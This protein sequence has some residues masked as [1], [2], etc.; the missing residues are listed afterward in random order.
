ME[1]LEELKEKGFKSQKLIGI[2]AI[3]CKDLQLFLPEGIYCPPTAF[4]NGKQVYLLREPYNPWGGLPKMAPA[5]WEDVVA[6]VFNYHNEA[7]IRACPETPR[8]GVLP[9][10]IVER[11]DWDK[12]YALMPP[13]EAV[14]Q[15]FLK[16]TNNVVANDKFMSI[17][18]GHDGATNRSPTTLSFPFKLNYRLRNTVS[19]AG[20]DVDNTEL[21]FLIDQYMGVYLVQIRR[22]ASAPYVPIC[23]R[24]KWQGFGFN[25]EPLSPYILIEGLEGLE[26]I[27]NL[28]E[29]TA[30]VHIGGS[31]NSHAAA[32][33]RQKNFPYLILDDE[34]SLDDVLKAR[35]LY[36]NGFMVDTRP[37]KEPKR[38]SYSF[39][40]IFRLGARCGE[41][42]F[43][44]TLQKVKDWV[45]GGT[46]LFMSYASG[47]PHNKKAVFAAGIYAKIIPKIAIMLC[48]GEARHKTRRSHRHKYP[49]VQE[50]LKE[51][52]PANSSGR[53]KL[54]NHFIFISD[55][56]GSPDY[57]NLASELEN[58]FFQETW[59][60]S[61]GGK[62]W[63]RITSLAKKALKAQTNSAII[64][65]VNLLVNALHNSNWFLDKLVDIAYFNAIACPE[66]NTQHYFLAANTALGLVNR[67][68]L[69]ERKGES[70]EKKI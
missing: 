21:E 1:F 2:V 42:Y 7:V 4:Y 19:L 41:I 45:E 49:L 34:K 66:N 47:W 67:I 48:L 15:P 40:E 16:D 59:E 6:E 28:Q 9:N 52:F 65:S 25:G 29:R 33:A 24:G 39:P 26:E 58:M 64:N 23:G 11:E 22:A 54:Y 27:E 37:Y 3:K 57:L 31:F 13:C 55:K 69:I 20:E 62:R 50:F 56:L 17:G 61:Y 14:I 44:T 70:Y 30:I 32:W 60:E 38:K 46:L 36:S 43:P 35:K 5:A 10:V 68:H 12:L 18:L 53:I 51:D 63:G 8:H